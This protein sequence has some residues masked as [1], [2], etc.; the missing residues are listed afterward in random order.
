MKVL[1][2]GG[3][4]EISQACMEEA[5]QAGHLVTV[6]NRGQRVQQL[7][8]GVEHIVGDLADTTV[9]SQLAAREFDVIC[10]FLAFDTKTVQRDID[11]FSGH[12]GQYVFISTA[13]A[14]QK[15]ARS[16]VINED[17]PLENPFWAYSRGKIACE[18]LLMD[19]HL[20]AKLPVTKIGR[21]NV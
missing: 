1:Y 21:A 12:C 6:F 4:G 16:H 5:S 7:P 8:V 10:Q 14:Y 19:A 9:Y 15:P 20:G 18:A 17:T 2:I 11:L 3:T 13:S